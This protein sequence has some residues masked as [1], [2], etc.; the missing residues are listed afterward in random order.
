MTNSILGTIGALSTVAILGALPAGAQET[1]RAVD[2]T[3][4]ES[5]DSGTL[6]R[7][8]PEMKLVLEKLKALGAK[9]VHTL[10]PAEARAQPTPADAVAA[11]IADQTGKPAIP[12]A[13]SKTKDIKVTGAAG[14]LA[15]RIYWPAGMEASRTPLPVILYFHGGGWVIA[16][17]DVYDGSARALANQAKAVVIATSY[18]QG[19]EDKFPSAHDDAVAVY[20]YVIDNASMWNGDSER[21]A[22]VGESAGGGLA[23]SVAIAALDQKLTTPDAIIAVYPIAGDD[24][25]TPSYLE[26]QNAAPL[27]KADM[28]WFFENYLNSIAEAADLRIDLIEADLKGLAPTTIISAEIDPLRSD[29]EMLRDQLMEAGVDVIYQNWNGVT[30]EFFGMAAVV[31]EAKEAQNL[32]GERL[33]TALGVK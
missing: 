24:T 29:G 15:A 12:E 1:P 6:E 20:K 33:R 30:H 28:E 5:A 10:T 27:G 21:L 14:E 22:L 18:R 3:V 32:V 13:V 16:N 25:D 26:N 31:P 7:A 11:V 9:P 8:N 4:A 23:L 2:H 19:P 17:I